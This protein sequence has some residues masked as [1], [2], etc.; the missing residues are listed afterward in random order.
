MCLFTM[1]Y[2]NGSLHII[3]VG[4]VCIADLRANSVDG[5]LDIEENSLVNNAVVDG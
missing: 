4:R 1:F 2:S 5:A 3:V